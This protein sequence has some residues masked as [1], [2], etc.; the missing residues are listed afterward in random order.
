MIFPTVDF[1]NPLL[2]YSLVESYVKQMYAYVVHTG[3]ACCKSVGVNKKLSQV[4]V[5][6]QAMQIDE[7]AGDTVRYKADVKAAYLLLYTLT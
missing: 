4:D 5:I 7:A 1:S 6:L 3:E 2:N